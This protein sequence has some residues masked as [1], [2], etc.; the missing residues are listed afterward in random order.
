[1]VDVLKAVKEA[2][3]NI[4]TVCSIDL[5]CRLE[6]DETAPA[7]EY[8]REAGFFVSLNGKT[9]VGLGRPLAKEV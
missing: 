5:N 6:E 9:N 3:K 4:S 8:A 2:S 1:M 7:I